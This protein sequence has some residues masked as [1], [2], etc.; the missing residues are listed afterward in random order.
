M[1]DAA[2]MRIPF[3]ESRLR[4]ERL[5]PATRLTGLAHR[6]LREVLRPGDVV[7]DA[8]AGNGHDTVF[9]ARE[10]GVTGHV[11]AMDIQE[12]AIERA[13]ARLAAAGLADRVSWIT[14]DHARL[15]A[16]LPPDR[17]GRLRA[18]VFNL[19]YL[20]GGDHGRV[21]HEVSTL[22]A[23]DA[24]LDFLGA[25][26]VLCVTCYRGHHGGEEEFRGVF[27]W[28]SQ[29]RQRFADAWF[30][31]PEDREAPPVLLFARI[32]SERSARQ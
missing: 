10:V 31:M 11:H 13:R 6:R 4:A 17:R 22:R 9:L 30:C 20:P 15:A 1:S 29:H 21:T 32:A 27:A 5:P 12:T 25:E 14:G 8:T 3:A 26:G 28:F 2:P 7:V 23:L 19:G 16:L 18:V 24:A